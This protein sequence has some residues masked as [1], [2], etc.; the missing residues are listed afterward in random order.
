MKELAE[1][2]Y[3][4][5][6]VPGAGSYVSSKRESADKRKYFSLNFLQSFKF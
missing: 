6:V 2:H 4:H 3:S 5:M 1:V